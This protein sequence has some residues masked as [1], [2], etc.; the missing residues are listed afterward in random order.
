MEELMKS[1]QFMSASGICTC[2]QLHVGWHPRDAEELR[3]IAEFDRVQKL[4]GAKLAG[5]VA[6]RS[7]D[8]KMSEIDSV[9]H[10]VDSHIDSVSNPSPYFPPI[11]SK[12]VT[13]S[14]SKISAGNP[15]LIYYI[16]SCVTSLFV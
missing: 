7:S 16:S 14:N 1:P 8:S 13:S 9:S 10:L 6:L 12:S 5:Y 11:A 3:R 2:C 4:S 15:V